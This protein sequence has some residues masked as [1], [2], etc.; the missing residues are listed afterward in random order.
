MDCMFAPRGKSLKGRL[1]R[2]DKENLRGQRLKYTT[3]EYC[4]VFIDS[5]QVV[6]GRFT[7][8]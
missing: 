7:C 3:N 1:E 4:V 5:L 6:I 8:K 2:A